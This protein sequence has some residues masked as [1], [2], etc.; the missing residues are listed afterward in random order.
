[1]CSYENKRRGIVTVISV[2]G[3]IDVFGVITRRLNYDA[4]ADN[5]TQGVYLYRPPGMAHVRTPIK[6]LLHGIF[7]LFRRNI[8]WANTYEC[9]AFV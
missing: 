4:V 5:A 3:S 7:S 1:M 6:A 2:S 9:D 8:P